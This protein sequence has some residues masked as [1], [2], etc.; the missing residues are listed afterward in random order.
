MIAR[1]GQPI[2][3]VIWF[4]APIAAVLAASLVFALPLKVAG[5]QAPEPAFALVPAFAWAMARPSVLPPFALIFLGLA[6]DLLWGG[7][8][9]VWPLCLLA[10]YALVLFGRHIVSGQEFWGL[11]G[12]Y[13][14]ACAVAMTV[15]LALISLR[16]GHVPSLVGAG[17]Q[18]GVSVLLFP[19]AWRMIER[20]EA[21]DT[22]YR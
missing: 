8:L 6:L 2:S 14:A 18:F 22:S 1:R 16:A 10:A 11:W 9:G 4:G 19:F 21:S 15:G 3:P 20:Y 17:L 5:L 12:W 7:A 13:A